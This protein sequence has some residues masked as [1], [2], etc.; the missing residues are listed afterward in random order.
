MMARTGQIHQRMTEDDLIEL[1]KEIDEK[2]SQEQ[3][4]VFSRRKGALDDDDNDLDV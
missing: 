1:I 2:K 3:K 4:I